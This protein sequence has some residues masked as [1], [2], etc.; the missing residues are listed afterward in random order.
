MQSLT[1]IIALIIISTP[2]CA[3]LNGKEATSDAGVTTQ[4][5][6]TESFNNQSITSAI[7]DPLKAVVDA[8]P[9]VFEAKR[10]LS[11]NERFVASHSVRRHLIGAGNDV[12]VSEDIPF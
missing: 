10:A 7:R 1:Y 12:F 2:N 3:P 8:D 5:N 9:R 6:A 11:D 4:A